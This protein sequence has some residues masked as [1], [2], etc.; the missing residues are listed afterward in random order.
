[1]R[2]MLQR[3][4][5]VVGMSSGLLTVF[6]TAANAKFLNHSEPVVQDHIIRTGSDE[7]RNSDSKHSRGR[8]QL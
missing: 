1:M 4:L 2:R 7:T 5:V 6:E 8:E 3:V